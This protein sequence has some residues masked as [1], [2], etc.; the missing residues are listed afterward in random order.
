[1]KTHCLIVLLVVLLL[2]ITSYAHTDYDD[3]QTLYNFVKKLYKKKKLAVERTKR[4]LKRKLE[5][6]NVAKALMNFHAATQDFDYAQVLVNEEE[7]EVGDIVI[8]N[9]HG[10]NRPGV[11]VDINGNDLVIAQITTKYKS[12]GG[13]RTIGLPIHGTQLICTPGL[14]RLPSYVNL[15]KTST[16]N[17]SAV[18]RIFDESTNLKARLIEESVIDMLNYLNS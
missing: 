17:K 4:D 14:H 18:K 12:R 5:K 15:S 7:I 13:I 1:M 6:L 16:A 8:Y 9:D 2:F 11:V 10:K 3:A